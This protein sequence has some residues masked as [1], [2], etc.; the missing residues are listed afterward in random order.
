MTRRLASATVL[1]LVASLL[2]TGGAVGDPPALT[3]DEPGEGE[4]LADSTPPISGT[5]T[6]GGG[7]V[8][9]QVLD[10][11]LAVVASFV[12][13]TEPAN[14]LVDDADWAAQARTC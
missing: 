3:I 12:E 7:N 13:A 9:V 8:T 2:I 6:N 10:A 5:A 14:W 11:G 1:A 4:V